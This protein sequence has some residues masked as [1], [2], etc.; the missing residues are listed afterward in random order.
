MNPP[1]SRQ[2]VRVSREPVSL[3]TYEPAAPERHPMFLEKRVY[4][5]SSGRVYPLPFT[6]RIAEKRVMHAWD[7]VTLENDFIR[8]VILPELGG[9]IHVGQDRTNGYDFFYRQEVIKPALVGLAGPWISGGVEFNWPQH[10]RPST[11]MP[12]DVHI[13]EHEDGAVT[14]WLGEHEPMSRMRGLHGVCLH[15]GRS[16]VE[17]KVRVFNRTPHP[18]TFLWWANAATRVHERY[19]SFFPDDVTFVADHAKRAMSLFP[20]CA[21][22]YYGVDYGERG[23]G[24]IPAAERPQHFVPRH[25]G[26]RETGPAYAANDLS[27]Y[28]NIPVPTSFMAMGSREDFFG[29][30]DHAAEAGVV[31]IANHHIA[32]G[33]KQWTWGNH[34][35]GYA[36]DRNLTDPDAS[37][38]HGPYIELMAGAYTDNQPDFSF[39]QPGETKTWSQYWY[40]IRAIG[41]P[42]HANTDAAV[43]LRYANKAVRVGVSVSRDCPGAQ[44]CLRHRER[45]LGDYE[46]DLTPGSPFVADV[47]LPRGVPETELTLAVHDAAGREI[48]AYRPKSV[49]AATREEVA[50]AA[51]SEPPAPKEMA[52]ADE[53]F[54]TGLHLAQYRHATRCPTLY[55]REALRRDPGDSR[56]NTAMGKWHLQR[57]ELAPAENHF[58]AAIARLTLR[59]PNPADGEPLYQLGLTLRLRA[60][61][62]GGGD[63]ADAYAA[64]YKAT[65]N[66]AW[67]AASYHALAEIDATRG[68][69]ASAV[70]HTGRVLRLDA[71]N[72]RARNLHVVALRQVGRSEEASGVLRET[73]GLDPLDWWARLL[74]GDP[75]ACDNQVRL[76]LAHDFVRAGLL[77]EAA[78]V[79]A[80]APLRSS[81]PADL[82]SPPLLAY[83]A[84]WIAHLRGDTRAQRT[85][86]ERAKAAAMDYCFPARLEEILVLESAVAAD[87]RDARAPLYLGH[88]L[89]DRRRHEEAMALW[90]R[91]VK[92]EPGNAVAWRCMG[93]GHFNVTADRG[94][95]RRAYDRALRESPSDARAAVRTGPARQTPRRAPGPTSAQAPASPRARPAAG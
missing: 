77:A 66:Q 51:A 1:A 55:W 8:V 71:D 61:A 34:A 60:L 33:K 16:V 74:A 22:R 87:A 67:A 89:Y 19:Q 68:D 27:W 17:V 78:S 29:G 86:L 14:V 75:L 76:D 95:A 58:R 10:H 32:P 85:H 81:N 56:S 43:S 53:L 57:G 93:I 44:V 11:F 70:E 62:K 59:N 45:I 39:L 24:G 54:V 40:P 94:K 47:K 65:W 18:Q 20:R 88:L 23:R 79:L 12:T 3:P 2:S 82:G 48:I 64:F 42:S 6:D 92:L 91:A 21:D 5:G 41:P 83:T 69:W 7:A 15:P 31:H 36:W 72:L 90:E 13:E 73:L 46:C 9:R 49:V 50:R 28:A 4:Q 25:A 38:V 26:G 52:S 80:S 84:A 37:G 63:L 30:Y 35:F